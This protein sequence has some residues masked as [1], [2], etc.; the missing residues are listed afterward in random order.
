MFEILRLYGIPERIIS[1]IKV[2]YTDTSSSILFSDGE[3]ESFSII[4][5]ILEGNTLT[6]FLFIVVVDYILRMSVDTIKI[7]ASK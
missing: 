4:T 2:L 1:A 3:T 6:P 7:R 5:G